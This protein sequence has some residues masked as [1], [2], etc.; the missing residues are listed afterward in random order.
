MRRR[1]RGGS[2]KTKAPTKPPAR[3]PAGLRELQLA[4]ATE[5]TDTHRRTKTLPA[6]L[7][8]LICGDVAFATDRFNRY[9][10]FHR[11]RLVGFVTSTFEAV[12]NLLPKHA[13]E[14]LMIDFL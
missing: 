2:S 4:F 3:A 10:R 5:L 11:M 7:S 9:K 1:V 13:S 14:Q 8:E 12:L 6:P